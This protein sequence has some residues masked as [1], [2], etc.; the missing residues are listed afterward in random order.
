MTEIKFKIT[1]EKQIY[2]WGYIDGGFAGIPASNNMPFELAK[3]LS[4]QYTGLKD[5]NGKEAYFN[6]LV[7]MPDKR[8]YQ[9]IW[10]NEGGR[11]QLYSYDKEHNSYFLEGY[12]LTMGEIVGN[13]YT[14]D[15]YGK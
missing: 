11:I 9:V 5:K 14:G 12:K 15:K 7:L 1:H 4:C 8:V 6:D 3:K 10:Y 2:Y 13:I